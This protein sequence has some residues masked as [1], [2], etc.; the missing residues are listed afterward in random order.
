[1]ALKD[2]E[3]TMQNLTKLS[4]DTLLFSNVPQMITRGNKLWVVKLLRNAAETVTKTFYPTIKFIQH[5]LDP[6]VTRDCLVVKRSFSESTKHVL[7]RHDNRYQG[8]I[9]RLEAERK[10]HYDHK[11][12]RD[13]GAEP[14]WFGVSYIP[15][16][17]EK[18]EI[19]IYFIGGEPTYMISTTPLAN[20]DRGLSIEHLLW[21]TPL[22][23]LV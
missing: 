19:R 4:K 17:K 9:E 15:E 2:F 12:V 13:F 11:A 21:V 8:N 1:M 20:D 14:L 3:A 7:I 16:M 22:T 10:A 23:H 5:P 18:G 6:K